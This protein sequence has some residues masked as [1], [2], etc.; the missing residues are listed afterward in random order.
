M[1]DFDILKRFR[2][3]PRNKVSL[4]IGP[5]SIKMLEVSG[6]QDGLSLVSF[7]MKK[8]QESSVESIMAS[9]KSLSEELKITNRELNISIAGPSVVVRVVSM[10]DM[11]DEELK[12]AIRFET[13]K[14]IPFNINECVLDFYIQGRNPREKN[15]LDILLAAAKKDFVLERVKIAEGAGFGINVVD[16][17]SFAITNAFLRNFTSIDPAKTTAL[18]N[19]ESTHT[20]LVILRGGLVSFVRDLA[21]GS[22]TLV[23]EVKLSFGYYENNSGGGVDSIY[24]SGGGAGSAG[25]EEIFND[26][27]GSK[28][29]RWN[30]VQFLRIDPLKVNVDEIARTSGSFAVC[31]GLALR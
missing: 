30:P 18:L 5:D 25:L 27:F 21:I 10:P 16:V 24:I 1:M 13:E 7:G 4:D 17:N 31:A 19:I 6:G 12:N 22:T 20:N 2:P 26:A 11:T 28:P 14:S 3:G 9:V 23:D 29:E 8:I 15:N